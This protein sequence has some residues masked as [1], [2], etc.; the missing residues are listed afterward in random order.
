MHV[1]GTGILHYWTAILIF[2]NNFNNNQRVNP[3]DIY[4]HV[5][6]VLCI[7]LNLDQILEQF[8][9]LLCTAK[10][11]LIKFMYGTGTTIIGP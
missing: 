2:N 10:R 1:T 5:P 11:F 3:F 9:F 4:R 6:I 7:L 8:I